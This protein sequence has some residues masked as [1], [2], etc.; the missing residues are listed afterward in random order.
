MTERNSTQGRMSTEF[1]VWCGRV[2]CAAFHQI[3]CR[4]KSEAGKEA[5]ADGWKLT[6]AFGWQCP[7]CSQRERD[8]YAGR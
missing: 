1:T 8:R 4:S 6:R 2:D 5:R 7:R 3:S